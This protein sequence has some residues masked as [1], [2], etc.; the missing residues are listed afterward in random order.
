MPRLLRNRC[1]YRPS[2]IDSFALRWPCS[3]LAPAKH[4]ITFYFDNDGNLLDIIGEPRGAD[5][6]AIAA[7]AADARNTINR[8]IDAGAI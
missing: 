7:M 4:S 6:T 1:T 3:G 5:P 8:A 2:E